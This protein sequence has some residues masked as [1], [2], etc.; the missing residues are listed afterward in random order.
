[1]KIYYTKQTRKMKNNLL[2][3]AAFLICQSLTAQV[4]IGILGSYGFSTST[5]ENILLGT[6]EGR[7]ATGISF[8]DQKNSTTF[9]VGVRKDFGPL[10]AEGQIFY[11]K[12]SYTL[13]VENFLQT[14]IPSVIVEEEFNVL[15]VPIIG[16]LKFGKV[17]IATGPTFNLH[18]GE[19]VNQLASFNVQKN[20]RELQMGATANIQYDIT[21]N[22]TIG[23]RYERAFNR[24]GNDY[25][26]GGNELDIKSKLDFMTFTVGYYL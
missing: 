5:S 12:S 25:R 3:I 20:K 6:P 26:Y 21:K 11:R 4:D 24:I 23:A 22:I 9:G 13:Q 7:K 10:F 15:H 18:I 17:R 16:G 19:S 2:I 8:V 14:D 1:M